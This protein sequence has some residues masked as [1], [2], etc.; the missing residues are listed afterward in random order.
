MF[1][2]MNNRKSPL[3]GSDELL[4]EA[5]RIFQYDDE[6]RGLIWKAPKH[7]CHPGK[8]KLGE[9][10]GGNDGHG[11]LGCMLLGH[12]FKVHQVVW[13]MHHGT[14]ADR[15][16]D[17]ANRDR[18]DNRIENLRLATDAEYMANNEASTLPVA[19]VRKDPKG[20]GYRADLS[21]NRKKKF[22]GYFRTAEEARA[23]YVAATREARGDFSP[24]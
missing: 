24:V 7:P 20:H 15:P 14:L 11:Y 16:I 13:L 12:K 8:M 5:H 2:R 9:R 6:Q 22:L 19:G 17:H 18:L 10:V 3:P 23:A 21:I 4:A 1:N